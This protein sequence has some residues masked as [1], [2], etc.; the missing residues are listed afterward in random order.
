MRGGAGVRGDAIG[1]A[2]ASRIGATRWPRPTQP[3]QPAHPRG[4]ARTGSP[5]A[6]PPAGADRRQHGHGS[7]PDGRAAQATPD[8]G[9]PGL[10]RSRKRSTPCCIPSGTAI[11]DLWG[12]LMTEM[13]GTIV[14][15]DGTLRLD[16]DVPPL[17]G[18]PFVPPISTRSSSTIWQ[19]ARPVRPCHR[20]R[21]WAAA[22]LDWVD[23]ER[24]DELHRQPVPVPAPPKGTV[25]ASL[26]SRRA[27]PIEAGRIP[28]HAPA[29]PAMRRGEE[30]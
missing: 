15:P 30:R 4:L 14:T 3:T 27:G 7:E 8:Q 17:P 5:R 6:T 10:R 22:A 25:P 21:A 18:L 20:R 1:C 2:P 29:T 16:R 28:G 23:L 13:L 19:P 12:D 26:R 11:S 24:P 9:R